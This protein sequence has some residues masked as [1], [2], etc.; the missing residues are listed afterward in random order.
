MSHFDKSLK[1][2]L[3]TLLKSTFS[4]QAPSIIVTQEL[5]AYRRQMHTPQIA[6]FPNGFQSPINILKL[7]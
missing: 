6:T 5:H 4:N 3:Q 7:H 1:N 2:D